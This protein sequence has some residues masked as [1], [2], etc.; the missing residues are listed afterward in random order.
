[1]TTATATQTPEQRVPAG[2]Y[3]LDPVHS[4][5]R[6]EVEHG[7]IS[8]F[9][10]SFDDVSAELEAGANGLALTGAVGVESID[11]EQPDLRGHLLSPEFFDA[12]RHP[13]IRFASR[14]LRIDGDKATL[15][16]ELEIRG[17]RKPIEAR[18]SVRGPGVGLDGSGRIALELATTVDRRDYGLDWQLEL[19]NG[20]PVLGWDV[21][22]TVSLELVSD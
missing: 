13:Q 22:L 18:G 1:M 19:P 3:R 17:E 6:F 11:V 2:T 10:G 14:E 20:E 5:A 12:E 4:S 16:G 7:S 21:T 15:D 9:H 8:R